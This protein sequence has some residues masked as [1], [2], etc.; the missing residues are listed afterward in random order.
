VCSLVLA[1]GDGRRL[2][3]HTYTWL[4]IV[5]DAHGLLICKVGGGDLRERDRFQIFDHGTNTHIGPFV[6]KVS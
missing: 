5:A 3:V 6:I 4:G 1:D 2:F